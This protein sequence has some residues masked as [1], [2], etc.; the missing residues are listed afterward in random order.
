MISRCLLTGP[1]F[2]YCNRK[3]LCSALLARPPRVDGQFANV[4]TLFPLQLACPL[5]CVLDL[6]LHIVA[7]ARSLR[8]TR[9][10]FFSRSLA[11]NLKFIVVL[12]SASVCCHTAVAGCGARQY[13]RYSL[14][15]FEPGKQVTLS[16]PHGRLWHSRGP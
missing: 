1:Y 8:V 7:P 12:V 13:I 9:R 5:A 3:L 10:V 16:R 6:F 2:I 11:R 4:L 15:A 14:A